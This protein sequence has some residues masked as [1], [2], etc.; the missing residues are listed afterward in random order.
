MISDVERNEI[1]ALIDFWFGPPQSAERFSQRDLWFVVNPEFDEALRQRFQALQRRAAQG[2]CAD[3]TREAEPCLALILLLD[4]LPRNLYRGT[5]EAF[6]TDAEARA[7]ARIALQR[8]FDR[9]LP[10]S[11]RTFIY[12]PFEHSEDLADQ[13]L[14]LTLFGALARDPDFARGEDYAKRHHAIIAR[15]GRFPHRNEALG[16]ASTPEEV[17]FLKEPNSSF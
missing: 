15:F 9:S 12:L 10:A 2:G 3:W 17:A 8:G 1:A 4:Q 6:A 16:R 5:A 14:S 11:W 13:E 7:A